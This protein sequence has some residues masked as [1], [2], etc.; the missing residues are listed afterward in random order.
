[1]TTSTRKQEKQ[2]K[3]TAASPSVISAPASAPVQPEIAVESAIPAPV[4]VASAVT[5][6]PE[7][8]AAGIETALVPQSDTAHGI[9]AEQGE[10]NSESAESPPLDTGVPS[11]DENSAP[12]AAV[13]DPANPVRV[14]IFPLRTY[15]DAGELKRRGGPAYLAPRLHA[16]QLIASGLA[17]DKSPKA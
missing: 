1:M 13:E 15:H 11:V 3:Q 7:M 8:P 9:I 10:I 17:T 2:T 16:T 5:V 14:A 6:E 4:P 12:E